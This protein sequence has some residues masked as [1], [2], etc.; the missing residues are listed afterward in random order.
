MVK[1]IILVHTFCDI[2][3]QSG[4]LLHG[5]TG[6]SACNDLKKNHYSQNMVLRLLPP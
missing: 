5:F 2:F 4:I 6:F 1:K 3:L